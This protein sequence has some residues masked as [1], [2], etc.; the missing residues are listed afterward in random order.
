[1]IKRLLLLIL[2]PLSSHALE[3]QS[4]LKNMDKRSQKSFPSFEKSKDDY[5]M[6]T[7]F[8]YVKD[9]LIVQGNWSGKIQP[10]IS[11]LLG[12]EVGGN[13]FISD[14]LS[15]GLA[16]PFVK[17]QGSQESPTLLFGPALELRYKLFDRLMIAP[18]YQMGSETKIKQT[19][20]GQQQELPLGAKKGVMGGRLIYDVG[21]LANIKWK[22]QVGMFQAPENKF[23]NLD[24]SSHNMA[25]LSASF[26]FDDK[27]SLDG[28]I[29]MDKMIS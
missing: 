16:L 10:I 21:E 18:Y 2:I 3:L 23:L 17:P 22:V 15:L 28:E 26:A 12:V 8:S 29:I 19:I 24:E 7:E 20:A 1:M 27:L 14:D 9:P 4:P 6:Y 13:W 25:G 11:G 5:N